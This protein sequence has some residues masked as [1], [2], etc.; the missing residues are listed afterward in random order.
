MKRCALG[1]HILIIMSHTFHTHSHNRRTTSNF[2]CKLLQVYYVDPMDFHLHTPIGAV[3]RTLYFTALPWPAYMH[4]GV[5]ACAG[6]AK[7]PTLPRHFWILDGVGLRWRYHYGKEEPRMVLCARGLGLP[8]Y[9]WKCKSSCHFCCFSFDLFK[10]CKSYSLEHSHLPCKFNWSTW[11]K[12][13]ML[14]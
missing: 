4:H 3:V 8:T 14:D 11:I 6:H 9:S 13:L 2:G 1:G 12:G 7:A 10:S 5:F